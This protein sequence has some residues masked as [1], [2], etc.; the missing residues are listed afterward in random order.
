MADQN[1]SLPVRTQTNGDVVAQLVDGTTIT[2]KLGIDSSG[3]IT[4]KLDD[5]AGNVV[6]SQTNG[7]QR[8]LDVGINVAGVQIDPRSIR[9]LTSADVVTAN[10][11]TA[12]TIAN[13]WKVAPTDGTN[14]QAYLS[15]GEAKVSVTQ[16]LPAG[17]NNIGSVNQGTSPWITKDQADGSSSGG[18]AGSFSM[19]VGG[20]FNTALPTLTTGQQASVQLDSSGRVIIA[21]LT[22]TSI[23]KAQLQDNS[24]AAI[25]LGQKTM[26]NSVPVVIS[27]DQSTLNTKDGADGPVTPGTVATNSMLAGGQF[28]TTLP[29]L[30][31]GQ[32]AAIQVDSNGRI[33]V[34]SIA[35]PLPAGTNLIGGTN[36]YV[37]GTIA[38]STN[39]VPVA[40]SS[41]PAG[42]LVN[43]ALTSAALAV[44]STANLDYTITATKT[45]ST[46]QFYASGSGKIKAVCSTSVDGTTF[47]TQYVGFNS[48][49]NPNILI[50]INQSELQTTGTGSKIRISIT[51]LDLLPQD[52]YA[53]ITGVEN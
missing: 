24:G 9:A 3:R 13:A 28:N 43:A 25:T 10:Q 21:P 34:S 48:T 37:G 16:P 38:S 14:S 42:T 2:Q 50:P 30:T 35:N 41:T 5:G 53:T 49:A 44:A 23:V 22:N 1:T 45:M 18:T 12:N 40:I 47:V 36:V 17:T 39:P 20:I 32:Q 26:A 19:Q 27:S 4:I 7:A 52:V 31:T 46:K 11:G 6:T 33:L 51:N 29:T 8:A 15:T